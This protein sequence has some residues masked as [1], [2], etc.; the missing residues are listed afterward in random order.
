MTDGVPFTAEQRL[1]LVRAVRRFAT[2]K[3]L[4]VGDVML[5][6]FIWGDVQR[7]SPEAPVPVVEVREESLLLGGSTNVVRNVASLGAGV[8]VAGVIGNDEPGR[9]VERLLK[10]DGIE[11]DGLVVCGER[12]TTVK[13]RVIA[14]NQ[15]VV[16]FDRERRVPL[17]PMEC[18]R[19]LE[20]V[21]DMLPSVHALVLSDYGKGVISG[22]LMAGLRETARPPG[23]PILLDPK[24]RPL[25]LYRGVTVI[26]PNHHEAALLTGIPIDNDLGLIEAGRALL[27]RLACEKVLITR[28]KDG[29][30][31][32]D[33]EGSVLHI[34]TVARRVFD[35]T[36]AGDTVIALMA[37]GLAAGLSAA[38]AAQL[39]NLAAGIVVGE[40][41]TACVRP[42]Q[43]LEA[44]GA[45]DSP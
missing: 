3:V 26:T 38:D 8:F 34:P 32:F 20:Y 14:Q 19:L 29:M 25:D 28:G 21:R 39:A 4:V 13:T 24:V 31:L 36:G 5:D 10:T 35:V 22:E 9:Q 7:I 40:V 37:L 15:Q 27:A 42:E 12:P 43:L 44:L 23:L 11:S 45:G 17:G 33:R 30:S 41:G 16:R 1:L 18:G 6:I 2:L